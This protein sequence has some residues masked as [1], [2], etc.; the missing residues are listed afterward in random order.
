MTPPPASLGAWEKKWACNVIRTPYNRLPKSL[1]YFGKKHGFFQITCIAV[2]CA[3][4][5][6]RS[7]NVTVPNWKIWRNC[8]RDKVFQGTEYPLSY[9]LKDFFSPYFWDAPPFAVNCAYAATGTVFSP[10]LDLSD[11]VFDTLNDFFSS[12][13][14]F[15][16][17]KLQKELATKIKHYFVPW[18]VFTTLSHKAHLSYFLLAPADVEDISK[19][20]SK[21]PLVVSSVFYKVI[22]NALCTTSA[23]HNSEILPCFACGKGRDDLFHFLRCSH[24][25]YIFQLPRS[26]MH[27]HKS[28][29]SKCNLARLAV[30]F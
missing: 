7:A 12:E 18:N 10:A 29:F 5:A 2:Q 28:Y 15:T 17:H 25:T 1:I 16:R 22:C 26:F 13:P 27:I 3:A 11:V 30:F 6:I 23:F 19:S 24:V 4:A 21:L 20:I 14:S 8:L 9:F